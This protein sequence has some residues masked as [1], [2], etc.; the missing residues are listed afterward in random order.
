M[1]G[2]R[3]YLL[4]MVLVVLLLANGTAPLA[5]LASGDKDY[6]Q[7]VTVTVNMQ[8]TALCEDDPRTKWIEE[9]FNIDLEFIVCSLND[10]REKTRVWI[11]SGDMPDIMWSEYGLADTELMDFAQSALLR[12]WPDLTNYPNLNAIQQG[13]GESADKLIEMTGDRYYYLCDGGWSSTNQI[14]PVGY[15]YRVDW[16]KKLGLFHENNTYTWDE[17]MAMAKAFATQDPDGDG[18]DDTIGLTS[19][20]WFYPM[21][22]GLWQ[23]NP[24]WAEF[25]KVDG[26]YVWG[27]TMPETLEGLR[28]VKEL[29][30]SGAL[31]QEQIMAKQNDGINK[32]AAGLAGIC[33]DNWHMPGT[34]GL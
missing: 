12:P 11:S 19:V 31:W 27:P 1:K 29:Y 7:K 8:N 25:T 24:Y 21:G 15:Y 26:K 28:Y 14:Q 10:I 22:Y 13:I 18:Q 4:L 6:S 17:V 9:K 30:D 2:K 20:S 5:A 33:G 34:T 3:T 16:A 23:T 32:F